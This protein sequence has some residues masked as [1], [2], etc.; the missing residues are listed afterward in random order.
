VYAQVQVA[1]GDP[2]GFEKAQVGTLQAVAGGTRIPLS[3]GQY[4]WRYTEWTAALPSI[5]T[6]TVGKTLETARQPAA[7]AI[8]SSLSAVGIVL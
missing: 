3:E 4:D 1:G 6:G 8:Y 5:P 2:I 7:D